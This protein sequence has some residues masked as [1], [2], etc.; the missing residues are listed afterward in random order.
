MPNLHYIMALMLASTVIVELFL[1]LKD[2]WWA[3]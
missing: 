3:Q 2:N 1:Q